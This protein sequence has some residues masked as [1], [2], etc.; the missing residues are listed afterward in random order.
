M[1]V[2][3][4]EW[5][6]SS[7]SIPKDQWGNDGIKIQFCVSARLSDGFVKWRGIFDDRDDFDNFLFALFK[8][9]LKYEKY[10]WGLCCPNWSPDIGEQLSYDFAT[11]I[12]ISS[13]TGSAQT[14]NRPVDWQNSGTAYTIGGGGGGRRQAT[15]GVAGAGGAGGGAFALKSVFIS[16][17]T[18]NY[19]IGA[20]GAGATTAATSGGNG[21]NTWINTVPAASQ[22]TT[23]AQGVLAVGGSGSTGAAGAAGGAAASCLGTTTFSGGTG[24]A[25]QGTNGAGG[26]GGGAGG[27]NAAGGNGTAGASGNGGNGGAG[28]GAVGGGG[29][30]ATPDGGTGGN[31][32]NFNG[33]IGSGGGAGGGGSATTAGGVGGNYGAGGGGGRTTSSGSASGGNGSQ[34]II[35]LFYEPYVSLR[36]N[37]PMLGM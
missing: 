28:N 34:G 32:T 23:L 11:F 6:P 20:F 25:G 13:P 8:G 33:T 24:G 37:I 7:Q 14:Y 29:A 4:K 12:T 19:Q 35:W 3:K 31:G 30:G 1:P 15:T 10:L 22:P 16:S 36:N 21:G 18:F 17:A 2:P 9:T 26:G 27:Q 5:M